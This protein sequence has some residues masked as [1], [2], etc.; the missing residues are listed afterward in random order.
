MHLLKFF[1]HLNQNAIFSV[2]FLIGIIGVHLVVL[3]IIKNYF[4]LIIVVPNS[5]VPI[6]IKK[7]NH[8]VKIRYNIIL[9]KLF[10]IFAK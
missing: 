10:K 6:F 1:R 9:K 8:K 5:R 4:K 2:I 7:N 3:I